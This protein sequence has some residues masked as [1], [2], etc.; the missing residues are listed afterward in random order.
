MMAPALTRKRETV[1]VSAHFLTEK[2]Q[3]VCNGL[4]SWDARPHK[5]GTPPLCDSEQFHAKYESHY[6][7]VGNQ[8]P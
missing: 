5:G 1:M 7:V 2:M 4:K 3:V 8:G 6:Q